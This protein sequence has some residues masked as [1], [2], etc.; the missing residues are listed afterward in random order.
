MQATSTLQLYVG[1]PSRH[2]TGKTLARLLQPKPLFATHLVQSPQRPALETYIAGQFE[3][4]YGARINE[5]MPLLVSMQCQGRFRAAAGIRDARDADLFVEQ[6]L[7]EP[8]EKLLGALSTT[9]VLR[10][11]IVEVGNLVSTHRGVSQLFFAVQAKVLQEAGFNWA[12]FAATRQVEKIINKLQFVTFRLGTADPA[13]LGADA[14]RW[15]S[16]YDTCP[17]VLAADISATV[18]TLRQSPLSAAVLALFAET[19]TGLARSIRTRA[20]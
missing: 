3:R 13:C 17:T 1:D 2:T 5:F 10:S 18:D 14:A 9:A 8:V 6:Y 19:I 4:V 11:D 20:F 7:S 16:Y 12:V 15:G